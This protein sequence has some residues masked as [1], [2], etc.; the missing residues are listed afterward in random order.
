MTAQSGK[1]PFSNRRG[2]RRST[3]DQITIPHKRPPTRMAMAPKMIAAI[4]LALLSEGTVGLMLVDHRSYRKYAPSV[5]LVAGAGPELR[6]E[7]PHYGQTSLPSVT[8]QLK[9][10]P[11]V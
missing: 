6:D 7:P 8:L 10:T 9:V 2:S 4:R 1:T 3:A 11:P 5:R